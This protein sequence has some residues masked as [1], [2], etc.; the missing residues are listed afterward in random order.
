MMTRTQSVFRENA[1]LGSRLRELAEIQSL[2]SQATFGS[3]IERGPIGALKHL[4]LEAVEAQQ[5][6]DDI[7]EYADCLLLLLDSS[8]RAGFTPRDLIEA[9]HEKMAVNKQRQWPRTEGDVPSQHARPME[10]GV[11]HADG[12]YAEHV[13]G[14][15]SIHESEA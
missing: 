11:I 12:G 9:A 8:R 13:P 1:W 4:A 2:W 15:R 5:R 7:V 14:H 3:D 6:P 10:V